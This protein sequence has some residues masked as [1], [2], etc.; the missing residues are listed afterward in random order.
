MDSQ[1]KRDIVRRQVRDGQQEEDG[2]LS[3]CMP[4]RALFAG[5]GLLVGGIAAGPVVGPEVA[6]AG[7]ASTWPSDQGDFGSHNASGTKWWTSNRGEYMY[8]I[9]ETNHH[10]ATTGS[11]GTPKDLSSV[12]T[13]TRIRRAVEFLIANGPKN[14]SDEQRS[15]YG[16]PPSDRWGQW[17]RNRILCQ[18]AIWLVTRCGVDV[19]YSDW[20]YNAVIG[21]T[22]DWLNENSYDGI[23]DSLE[24]Y[25]SDACSYA[26]GNSEQYTGYVKAWQGSDGSQPLAYYNRVYTTDLWFGVTAAAKNGHALADGVYRIRCASNDNYYLST[27]ND[28]GQGPQLMVWEAYPDDAWKAEEF[29]LKCV[30]SWNLFEIRTLNNLVLT[31]D[32]ANSGGSG[33]AVNKWHQNNPSTSNQQF[34]LEHSDNGSWVIVPKHSVETAL[35]VSG[36]LSNGTKVITRSRTRQANGY[37]T[38][39]ASQRWVLERVDT[40]TRGTTQTAAETY[41]RGFSG[42]VYAIYDHE[43]LDTELGRFNLRADGW[44]QYSGPWSQVNENYYV[45]M[46]TCPS[47]YKFDNMTYR[48]N[49]EQALIEAG[50]RPWMTTS[51]EPTVVTVRFYIVDLGGGTHFQTSASLPSGTE[52]TTAAACF[53]AAEAK[54]KANYPADFDLI[55]RWYREAA[56]KTAFATM[57]LGGDLNL[58]GRLPV[59]VTFVAIENG[60]TERRVYAQK[61]SYLTSFGPTHEAVTTATERLEQAYP[62]VGGGYFR[63]WFTDKGTDKALGTLELTGNL[64]LYARLPVTVH[65]MYLDGDGSWNEVYSEPA[66]YKSTVTTGWSMFSTADEKLRDELGVEVMDYVDRWYVDRNSRTNF[67]SKLVTGDIWVYARPNYGA[68]YYYVDGT[69]DSHIVQLPDGSKAIYKPIPLGTRVSVRNEVTEAARRPNCTPGLFAWYTDPSDPAI[70][71]T[72][73]PAGVSP[74]V[75]SGDGHGL[76]GAAVRRAAIA[77]GSSRFTSAL[78]TKPILNLYGV[79]RATI[80]YDYADGSEVPADDWEVRTQPSHDAT[81]TS[82]ALPSPEQALVGRPKGLPTFERVYRY[83]GGGSWRALTGW[84]WYTES[85]ATGSRVGTV[86]PTRD[87]TVYVLWM[88][89][90]SDGIADERYNQRS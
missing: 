35:D 62:K 19:G 39:S 8:C 83:M 47:G 67:T 10:I 68:V 46:V 12:L 22:R 41:D 16:Q 26:K 48:F 14:S 30:D 70:A 56:T 85:T 21:H 2:L 75:W 28:S 34:Y 42:G 3:L 24:W 49:V 55:R 69:D 7:E 52:L 51:L 58:Y 61:L 29:H 57:T 13:N 72:S 77:A 65:F 25:L 11:N 20:S 66:Q 17:W 23:V 6:L 76:R 37:G 45:H 27:N 74:A 32:V 44:G 53:V 5:L 43:N 90:T 88:Y 40:N 84:Y 79:N 59:T 89:D 86:T 64:T 18:W 82:I 78:L 80:T 9:D 1:E 33:T 73:A 54:A 60:G 87:T 36:S 15:I 50:G 4:R 38:T 71:D 31:L 63:R 81:A